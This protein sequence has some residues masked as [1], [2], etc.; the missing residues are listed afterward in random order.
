MEKK[1]NIICTVTNN[2]AYD[3]RM[4][5]I[6]TS[7]QNAGYNVTLTGRWLKN[8]PQ[9]SFSFNVKY[10]KCYFNKTF[11]FYAEYNIRLLFYLITNRFDIYYAVDLDTL[12]PNTIA[13]I[14]FKKKLVFDA[15]EYFTETP[16]VTNR[17]LVKVVWQT[18]ANFCIPKAN[19]CI[20]VGPELTKLFSKIYNRAFYVVKNVPFLTNPIASENNIEKIILYQGALN[21]SRGL[22]ECIRAMHFVNNAKLY[23]AGE[24]DLSSNLRKLVFELNLKDK[25]KFL[26]F[27]K[28]DE[29][30]EI[31]ANAYIGLNLLKYDG[32][33][34][35]YSLANK[36]FD[37]IMAELPQL[38]ADFPEYKNINNTYKI[39]LLTSCNVSQIAD[40]L[41]TLLVNEKL[42]LQLKQNCAKARQVLNWQQEEKILINLFKKHIIGK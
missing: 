26:G 25:V 12:L 2:L 3:Q 21:K 23:I 36:F 18:I 10:F 19:L 39:A 31:T 16:E 9:T 41:N 17:P 27:I 33:S 38:C 15:H 13:K 30:K 42:Y 22:E 24:G 37:Y 29:L 5:R 1:L 8:T 6:C 7:L 20:T 34:Y 11:L 4:Q 32:E 40:N 28:P 35:Y 14:I